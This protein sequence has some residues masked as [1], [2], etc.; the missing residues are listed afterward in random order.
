M[1]RLV[2]DC[3]AATED[4]IS[5]KEALRRLEEAVQPVTETEYCS[6]LGGEGRILADDIVATTTVPPRDN[7]AVDGYAFCHADYEQSPETPRVNLGRSAAGHPFEGVVKPDCV[8][9]IL[10]GAVMPDGMDSVAMVEDVSFDGELVVLPAGLKAGANCR[11]AGEDISPGQPLLEKGTLLRPQEIGYLSSV[12]AVALPV[13][14]RLRVGLF[15]T[16]DELVNP[17]DPPKLGAIH[18]SNRFILGGILRSFGC[19]VTDLGILKD[20]PEDIEAA[21]RQA[22]MDHDV[23]ITS[24]GVSMG[25]EDHVKSALIA[26]GNLHFWKIAIKPG[27]PLALG[28]IGNSAFV[29]LPGNPVAA[30][31]CA[32]IFGRPLIT[33][34]AGMKPQNPLSFKIPSSFSFNKKPG[35]TEWLRGRYNPEAGGSGT[36]ERFHTE[37]SGILTSTVW[38]NG[39]IELGDEVTQI[40]EGDFVTFLPF[41]ELMR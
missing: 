30:L 25:D 11:K 21:L 5:A 38:A 26:A 1:T 16:G 10:T 4:M 36:V 6:L 3:F 9:K 37:G 28:Q 32:L 40:E 33:K 12:G 31:V 19:A 17:G 2:N 18:D 14:T 22:A 23:I 34:L 27:R 35:R 7:S 24:G 15:S 8:V 13:R 29:G 20:Q 41:S 39:L